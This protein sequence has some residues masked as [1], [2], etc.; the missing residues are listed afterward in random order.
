MSFATWVID[1]V[2]TDGQ[3]A[4][5]AIGALIGAAGGLVAAG[6]LECTQ[7]GTPNMS[8]QVAVGSCWVPGFP[9]GGTN[10]YFFRNSATYERVIAAAGATNPRV[11]TVVVRI[12]DKAE[13]GA[14]EEALIEALKG[15]ETSEATLANLD[16]IAS[17]PNGCYVLAYVL[18]PAKATT[19][20]TVDIK[21]VAKPVASAL[22]PLAITSS[23]TS[24]VAALGQHVEMLVNAGNTVTLPTPSTNAIV[25]V[26]SPL[27]ESK[28][29]TSAGVIIGDFTNANEIKLAAGQ[30]LL[31]GGDGT[32]WI[33]I[34]GEP[35]LETVYSGLAA[36]T[37][38][39][40]IEPSPTRGA[41][42]IGHVLIPGTGEPIATFTI[43]GV[44]SIKVGDGEPKAGANDAYFPFSFPINPGQKWSAVLAGGASL[45]YQTLIH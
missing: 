40:E 34:A 44:A 29:K 17:V 18:V 45:K 14:G 10:P 22:W 42:V 7:K 35:K 12:K 1:G 2:E 26:S 16:G 43:G 28:V 19:I 25:A 20:V 31:L 30:H 9:T 4:R 38:G 6:N 32:N 5:Q 15:T 36:Y 24:V 39:T 3:V 41:T 37:S 27:V 23:T 11:D 8:V 13:E 21:N 33:I